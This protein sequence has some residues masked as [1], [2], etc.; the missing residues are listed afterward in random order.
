MICGSYRALA[1]YR[2]EL[3]RLRR[4]GFALLCSPPQPADVHTRAR[5]RST[6][7]TAAVDHYLRELGRLTDTSLAGRRGLLKRICLEH[8]VKP[9]AVCTRIQREHRP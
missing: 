5:I 2:D 4:A 6:R 3:D 1:I 7:V 8:G 9:A